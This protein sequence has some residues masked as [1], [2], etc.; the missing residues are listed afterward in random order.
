MSHRKKNDSGARSGRGGRPRLD[1]NARRSGR[2]SVPVNR[3]EEET[4]ERKAQAIHMKKGAFLRHL[5]MNRR[6]P[7][8]V[9]AINFRAYRQLGRLSGNFNQLVLHINAGKSIGISHEFAARILDEIRET[10][11]LLLKGT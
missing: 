6:T 8:P 7:R 10:Q 3:D 9:P 2:I 4:I 5:G 11:R 1:E